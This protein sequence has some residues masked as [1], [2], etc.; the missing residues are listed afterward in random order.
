LIKVA[1]EVLNAEPT[2]TLPQ[3]SR[4]DIKEKT[5]DGLDR[6]IKEYLNTNLRTANIISDVLEQAGIVQIVR[7]KN[8]RTGREVK[9][10]KLLKEWCW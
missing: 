2:K 7:I 8:P 5:P 4:N 6:R 10:T 3:N 9:G 1:I